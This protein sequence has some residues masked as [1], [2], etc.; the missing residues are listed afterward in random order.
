MSRGRNA[1]RRAGWF[2]SGGTGWIVDPE[3]AVAVEEVEP[4]EDAEP[5]SDALRFGYTLDD[6]DRLTRV[7]C[8]TH[9]AM[10]CDFRD[11]YAEAYGAIVEELYSATEPPRENDLIAVG[12][13]AIRDMVRAVHRTHGLS[14]DSGEGTT[15]GVAKFW[16]DISRP[17]PSPEGRVVELETL[18]MIWPQLDQRDREALLAVAACDGDH[19]RAATMLG[20]SDR[21]MRARIKHAC[22][23]FLSWWHEGERPSTRWR[24][25]T[26]RR[27]AEDLVPCG[28]PSAYHRH[29]RRGEPTDEACRRAVDDARKARNAR[30]AMAA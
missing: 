27:R 19:Y 24:E 18:R 6:V 21:V 1:Y 13:A 5:G 26:H 3:Q 15:Y 29:R 10:A 25:Q 22:A 17:T 2:V 28:T 9:H 8:K 11:R 23:T 16:W 30:K 12:H 4:V 20:V 7:V 14:L